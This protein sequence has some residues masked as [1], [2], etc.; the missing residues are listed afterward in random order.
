MNSY[1]PTEILEEFRRRRYLEPLRDDCAIERTDG[2]D[3]DSLLMDE[4]R[5]WYAS[6]ID[7]APPQWLATEDVAAETA[8]KE[9]PGTGT[10]ELTLPDDVRRVVSLTIEGNPV[11]AVPITDLTNPLAALQG[12]P[13]TR[14][15]RMRP[16]AILA[17]PQRI[18]LYAHD[19]QGNPPRLASLT[20]VRLREDI[21]QF[22]N[23]AWETVPQIK[24]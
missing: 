4:I 10:V 15:G 13:F 20:A 5:Q 9:L 1:T 12:S 7:T 2:P 19:P 22:D 21:Y 11:P 14:G 8:V 18:I 23:R 17:A 16:V 6:L 3:L 24:I